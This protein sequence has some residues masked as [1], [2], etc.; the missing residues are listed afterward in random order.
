MLKNAYFPAVKL[1]SSL[2][3]VSYKETFHDHVQVSEGGS[4]WQA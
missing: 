1:N 3:Q 2:L 4:L